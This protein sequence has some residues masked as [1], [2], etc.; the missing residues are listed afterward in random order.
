VLVAVASGGQ[1]VG[2]VVLETPVDLVGEEREPQLLGEP[3]DPVEG[4]P[5][6]QRPG[7]VVGLVD[8]ED[9]R[10]G[11]EQAAEGVEVVRPTIRMNAMPLAHRG[12][13]APGQL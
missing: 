8:V 13:G 12:T 4:R 3:N 9:A 10:A 5:G 7:G 6:H 11:L 1:L 2:R